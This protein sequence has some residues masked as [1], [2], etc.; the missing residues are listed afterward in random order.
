MHYVYILQ[1]SDS[2]YYHGYSNNLKERMKAHETGTVSSTK[3]FRPLKLEFYAAFSS[4]KKALNFELYLKTQ[5]GYAFR[6]KRLV[7]I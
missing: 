3:N 5:S 1:L 7:E 2:T 4:K 6:N